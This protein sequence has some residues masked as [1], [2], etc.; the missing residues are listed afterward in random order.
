MRTAEIWKK[1]YFWISWKHFYHLLALITY[2]L[3]RI[4]WVLCLNISFILFLFHKRTARSVL[5][6][7]KTKNLLIYSKCSAGNAGNGISE[8]SIKNILGN[9]RSDSLFWRAF[10]ALAFLLCVHLQNLS[11]CPFMPRKRFSEDDTKVPKIVYNSLVIQHFKVTES[12]ALTKRVKIEHFGYFVWNMEPQVSRFKTRF[13]Q[14][15]V[16]TGAPND[17]FL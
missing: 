17:C 4:I 9:M 11:L 16:D 3:F 12:V 6:G 7:W 1:E 5:V 14:L 10:R 8:T 2:L 15:P 13:I